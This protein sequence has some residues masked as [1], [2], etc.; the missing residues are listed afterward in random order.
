MDLPNPAIVEIPGK[1]SDNSISLDYLPDCL[2]PYQKV[3]RDTTGTYIEISKGCYMYVFH[4]P[5]CALSANN[6]NF[7]MMADSMIPPPS[8]PDAMSR[9]F[10]IPDKVVPI[11]EGNESRDIYPRQ[12]MVKVGEGVAVDPRYVL[13]APEILINQYVLQWFQRNCQ[14]YSIHGNACPCGPHV[15]FHQNSKPDLWGFNEHALSGLV[16]QGMQPEP[17]DEDE[18]EELIGFAGECKMK[19]N[20]VPQ[21]KANMVAVAGALAYRAIDRN[22]DKITIHGLGFFYEKKEAMYY[23][24]KLDF[25]NRSSRFYYCEKRMKFDAIL[26]QVVYMLESPSS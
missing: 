24:L 18:D 16:I 5:T 4:N 17:E 26:P 25:K 12:K 11:Y 23:K 15:S 2:K 6:K 9:N 1:C 19:V 22:F 10:S 7:E 21:L 13:E 14:N 3:G 20:C 8:Y